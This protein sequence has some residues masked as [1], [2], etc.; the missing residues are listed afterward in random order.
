VVGT[1]RVQ[2]GGL[3]DVT[4]KGLLGGS[5][6]SAF[7]LR[8]ETFDATDA[9]VAGAQGAINDAAGAGYGG[10]G[11]SGNEGGVSN[12]PYGLIEDAR[13]LGSGGGAPSGS[14]TPAGNGG[15]RITIQASSCVDS[16]VIRANR[17]DRVRDRVV[18]SSWWWGACRDPGR[19]R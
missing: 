5:N 16:G 8:G 15:G 10:T 17:G 3:I 9:I 2:A 4:A 11:G 13:H 19:S 14:T 18:R 1:L 6:G 7:G 12:A